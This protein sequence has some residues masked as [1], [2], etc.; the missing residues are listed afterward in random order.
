[1]TKWKRQK[2][3]LSNTNVATYRTWGRTNLSKH[4]AWG[5]TNLSKHRAWGRT[6][7][8]KHRA[9]GRTN[10]T[11][12][13]AWWRVWRYQNLR[14]YEEFEDTKRVI[15]IRKSN[16]RQHKRKRTSNDLQSTT[17][18]TKDRVTRSPL[19]IGVN[20]DTPEGKADSKPLVTP[21]WRGGQFRIYWMFLLML[22]L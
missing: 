10:L 22:A 7:L 16:D 9:R 17:H 5:W 3:T 4:R 20:S 12:H 13:R 1:M 11:K 2:P 15:R 18:K 21:P 8:T 6:N 14:R 19:N